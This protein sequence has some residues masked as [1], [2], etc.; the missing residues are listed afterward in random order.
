MHDAWLP[1]DWGFELVVAGFGGEI[2]GER[3]QVVDL[4]I[5]NAVRLGL[6]LLEDEAE[7]LVD[8]NY[9]RFIN[10]PL[11]PVDEV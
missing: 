8:E 3:V 5:F 4:E 6:E 11:F 9:L 1:E 7:L 2:S 10:F